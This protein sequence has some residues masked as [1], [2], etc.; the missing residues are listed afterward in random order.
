MQLHEHGETSNTITCGV[1]HAYAPP[2]RRR[3][4]SCP[5]L[6]CSPKFLFGLENMFS[7]WAL[8]TVASGG[9]GWSTM[10]IG[11]VGA[12]SG[13]VGRAEGRASVPG[14]MFGRPGR[15]TRDRRDSFCNPDVNRAAHLPVQERRACTYLLFQRFPKFWWCPLLR[16][17]LDVFGLFCLHSRGPFSR[18][19]VLWLTQ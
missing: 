1:R 13:A 15:R 4:A 18:P 5:A 7:L 9:L 14:W 6:R 10:Q 11:Q 2:A 19:T 12:V 16:C 8:S 17:C 3:R